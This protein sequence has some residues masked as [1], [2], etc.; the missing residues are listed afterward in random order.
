MSLSCLKNVA[1]I[2]LSYFVMFGSMRADEECVEK[3]TQD[4]GKQAKERKGGRH[5]ICPI[6]KTALRPFLVKVNKYCLV[7]VTR[8]EGFDLGKPAFMWSP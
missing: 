2:S 8:L 7:S 1:M 4:P 3:E 6:L 5:G